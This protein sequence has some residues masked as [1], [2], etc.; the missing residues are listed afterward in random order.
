M[1]DRN[2]A[3]EEHNIEGNRK[4]ILNEWRPWITGFIRIYRIF[5]SYGVNRHK[6]MNHLSLSIKQLDD[7]LPCWGGT[8]GISRANLNFFRVYTGSVILLQDTLF[9]QLMFVRI[10]ATCRL[11]ATIWL[12]DNVIFLSLKMNRGILECAS[13]AWEWNGM[14]KWALLIPWGYIIFQRSH[15][16]NLFHFFRDLWRKREFYENYLCRNIFEKDIFPMD[17]CNISLK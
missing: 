8:D 3:V 10:I 2:S 7:S 6:N 16:S 4:Q 15:L 12:R 5:V 17:L 14:G 9:V 13:C 11:S 1:L